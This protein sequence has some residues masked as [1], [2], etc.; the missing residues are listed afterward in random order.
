MAESR[1]SQGLPP[2]TMVVAHRGASLEAPENTLQAFELAVELGADAV[3]FD[4]RLTSDGV[5]VIMHDPDVARTTDGSGLVRSLSLAEFKRL[6]SGGTEIP[7]LAQALEM[8][9]GRAAVDLE[10]KNIPGEPDFDPDEELVEATVRVVDAAGFQG[11]VIVSSFNP[12]SIAH[13]LA[14]AP[15][16][17]TG[18]L[19][20]DEVPAAAALSHVVGAG[21]RWSLPSVARVLDAP[22]GLLERA[23]SAGVLVGTWVVDTPQLARE[24]VGRGV[25][26]VATNDAR[27][28]VPAVREAVG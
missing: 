10:L 17:A 21:H 7:T 15:E 13:A 11:D 18:L 14:L 12:L 19:T 28:I 23:H 1:F 9:S 27:G 20:T 22:Q 5:P 24:L 6:R 26:A 4:L 8:L 2:R 3:E 25:D 16:M